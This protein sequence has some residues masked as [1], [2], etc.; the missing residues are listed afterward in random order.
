MKTLQSMMGGAVANFLG[1][2]RA[3]L[4]GALFIV[5]LFGCG[6]APEDNVSVQTERIEDGQLETGYPG[7]V[8]TR[9]PL[10]AATL[11]TPSVALGAHH[12]GTV[13]S[14]GVGTDYQ[15]DMQYYPVDAQIAMP[16]NDLRLMHLSTPVPNAQVLAVSQNPPPS[17]GTNC[18]AVGFGTHH[19]S[20]HEWSSG[21]KRSAT[22]VVAT[23]NQTANDP[24]IYTH[25]VTGIG[26]GGDSG[27]PLLCGNSIAGVLSSGTTWPFNPS[28]AVNS[29]T[30]VY[31]LWILANIG[32]AP[33][34]GDELAL[35]CMEPGTLPSRQNCR[36]LRQS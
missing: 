26:D 20:A 19:F 14:V 30:T 3:V 35:S 16:F 23:G 33:P 34:P 32:V 25:Y 12:C 22:E 8:F 21:I 7:V 5:S 15:T 31:P 28:S 36:Q 13:T 10:C 1:Q 17:V 9:P 18:T 27:S 6:A 24:R 2:S 29:Y 11:I 4:A